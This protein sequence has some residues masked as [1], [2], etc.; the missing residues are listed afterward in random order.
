MKRTITTAAICAFGLTAGA[1]GALAQTFPSEPIRMIVPYNPGGGTDVTARILAEALADVLPQP[2]V[3][4]NR[5]GA[6]GIV[7]TVLATTAEPDGH[8][9]LFA[10][11]ATVAL[12]PSLFHA[13]TYDAATDLDAVAL[14]TEAPYVITVPGD[15]AIA[16][17]DDLVAA[18]SGEV[19]FTMA[20]GASAAY[21]GAALLAA[22]TGATFE[23][24][25]YSGTGDAIS[26]AL[27]GR[28][29]A[30]ISSPV[31]VLP[32]IESGALRAIVN[33]GA[34]RFPMLPDVPTVQESGIDGFNVAG[35][36]A[37]AAPAGVPED[38]LEILNAAF[39]EVIA[40]EDVV[41]QLLQAGV[42]ASPMGLEA[43]EVSAF[44]QREIDLWSAEIEAAGIEKQ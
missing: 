41:E 27:S 3:I 17:L 39:N 44:F 23:H 15:S 14:L 35:W 12:N 38:R 16:D 42:V 43:A 29:D 36:Y 2:V 7:G 40:R 10:I 4:E 31:A 13:A 20:N 21:L 18:A 30:L 26:D 8:T 32:H 33:T 19:R 28:V 34:N 37:V 9:L 1:Q 25:P 11:Q 24:I 22:E 6:S 5:P